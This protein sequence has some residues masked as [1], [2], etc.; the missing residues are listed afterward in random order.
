MVKIKSIDGCS[1]KSTIAEIRANQE[2]VFSEPLADDI[3]ANGRVIQQRATANELSI[4]EKQPGSFV[5]GAFKAVN[6]EPYRHGKDAE[7]LVGAVTGGWGYQSR[8]SHAVTVLAE[9]SKIISQAI[10][11][12]RRTG[13]VSPP[14]GALHNL[15]VMPGLHGQGVRR[16]LIGEAAKHILEQ[17]LTEMW[18]YGAP[19]YGPEGVFYESTGAVTDGKVI[20]Q[21]LDN[22]P[23]ALY[24]WD[25]Q[26]LEK[27][28]QGM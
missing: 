16:A 1:V 27:L 26:A 23:R 15:D 10:D 4:L 11:T 18:S 20:T 7:Q 17:G 5:F 24:T 2:I 21:T 6:G 8:F 9:Q 25:T 3:I 28:S 14:V 13:F 12:M 22:T 19:G